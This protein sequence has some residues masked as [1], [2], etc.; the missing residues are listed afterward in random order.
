MTYAELCKQIDG[1]LVDGLLPP[2]L[3]ACIDDMLKLGLTKAQT[4]GRIRTSV[5]SHLPRG[6]GRL[7][8]AAVEAY[9]EGKQ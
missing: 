4:L 8:L 3:K 7:T 2:S 5:T 9:L 1:L 6:K